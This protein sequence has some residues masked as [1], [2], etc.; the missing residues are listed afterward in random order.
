MRRTILAAAAAAV[1]LAPS[2]LA[3]PPTITSVS[4]AGGTL[5][6]SWTLPAGGQVW[7]VEI[8]KSTGVDSDGYFLVDDVVDTQV[9]IDGTTSWTS[10][11]ALA[12]GT[13]YVHASGWDTNCGSCPVPE[14]SA[15]KSFTV[16]SGASASAAPAAPSAPA[17]VPAPATTTAP[18][19]ETAPVATPAPAPAP[20][21]AAVSVPLAVTL[22]VA[23]PAAAP[24]VESA[25]QGSVAALTATLKGSVAVVAFRVCGSGTVAVPVSVARGGRSHDA[26]VTLPVPGSGCT[27]YTLRLTAPAGTGET[28]VS[29]GGLSKALP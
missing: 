29:V 22:P 14:W 24:V 15:I 28:S 5:T 1:L 11:Q 27:A 12:P 7:T 13:Y 19:A 2:A 20:A 9:F 10:D 26:L 8:S 3:A 6:A 4:A 21:A 23:A 25:P 18:A 16:G 17:T